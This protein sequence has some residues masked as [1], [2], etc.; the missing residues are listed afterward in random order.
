MD[1]SSRA[2]SSSPTGG[3]WPVMGQPG[4]P[5][6]GQGGRPSASAAGS[7]Q[8]LPGLARRTSRDTAPG[9]RVP[10]GGAVPGAAPT[11]G[12]WR[13][14]GR[15]AS[16]QSSRP[17]EPID[18]A[19][20]NESAQAGRLARSVLQLALD[21]PGQTLELDL[22][23]AMPGIPSSARTDRTL[24]LHYQPGTGMTMSTSVPSGG[25]LSFGIRDP[26]VLGGEVDTVASLLDHVSSLSRFTVL[27]VRTDPPPVVTGLPGPHPHS[28]L[29]EQEQSLIGVARWP[30]RTHNRDEDPRQ[31]AYGRSFWH[32]TR[33]AGAQLAQGRIRSLRELW[34]YAQDW[35]GS[36]V[37][38]RD[39]PHFGLASQRRDHGVASR[40]M[41]PLTGPYAYLADRCKQRTD[42]TLEYPQR[43]SM[44]YAMH[45]TIG[46]KRLALTSVSIRTRWDEGSA[47]RYLA[48]RR[49]EGEPDDGPPPLRINHTSVANAQRIMDHAESL[50]SRVMDPAI[51]PADALATLGELH[52]WLSHAMPDT[53]GSAAK[54]E[55]CVRSL[56]QARGMD[57]PP[58]KPGFVPD[59]EAMI[60]PRTDYVDGYPGAFTRPPEAP[61]PAAA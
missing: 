23:L 33:D 40:D 36:T 17:A 45:D 39:K 14:A 20:L 22:S 6:A 28:R 5:T 46:G 51:P 50:F 4:P 60:R 26:S 41:T 59:L 29:S 19:S 24:R 61:S 21:R 1:G 18:V 32:T 12:L 13:A 25:A 53:R 8:D 54:A 35:R 55:L 38:V 10:L 15:T 37:P 16:A 52:W 7:N 58:F 3:A 31:Q 57:L 27:R 56:A 49:G 43:H 47:A 42:G 48:S 30:D 2:G 9:P 44:R 11:S 34:T